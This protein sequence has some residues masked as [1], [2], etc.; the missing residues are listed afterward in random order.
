M[1][2]IYTLLSRFR[3]VFR[4]R[5]AE[6]ELNDELRF[7]IELETEKNI[8]EGFSPHEAR[9]RALI[10]FGAAESYKEMLRDRRAVRWLHD[11]HADTRY[12]LRCL[13]RS[14]GF[15]IVAVLTLGLGIGATTAIFAVVNAVLLRPLPYRDSGELAII[16][17]QNPERGRKGS[18][19]SYL[20]YQTW[21]RE[22]QSFEGLAVFNW[23]TSTISGDDAQAERVAG[24]EVDADLFHVL[25]VEPLLGRGVR[26]EEQVVG[27]DRVVVLGYGLWQRRYGGDGGV[28]GRS[29]NVDGQPHVIIGVMP[30]GFRFPNSRELWLP[31]A[32][33]ESYAARSSRFLAGAVSRLRKGVTREQAEAELARVSGRLQR[34]FPESNTGWEGQYVALRDD[35]V[36]TL[37]PAILIVFAAAGL[38]L[39]IACGNLAS[40]LLAR[41]A[42][43][44]REI[45]LRAAIGARRGRLM[46]QFLTET[47]V[48]TLLG[49]LLGLV[50]AYWGG[51]LL[52]GVLADR[53]PA[54]IH[55]TPDLRV[56]AFAV[57]ATALI[58]VLAG[59]A[60]ALQGTGVNVQAVMKVGGRTTAGP[61]GTRAR[62]VLVIAEVALAVVL[63]IGSA[64]LIKSMGALSRIEAGFEPRNVLTARYE[65]PESKYDSPER[66][67]IFQAALFEQ[68]RALPGVLQVGAAAG[69]PFSGWNAKSSYEVEGEGVA[70]TGN[71]PSTHHQGD[72]GVLRGA[73]H[74][75]R[76]R[77]HARR[78]GRTGRGPGRGGE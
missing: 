3:A 18:N 21:K 73:R 53:I 9:R 54:V 16:Y 2:A 57:A 37:R 56:F 71:E 12:A 69:M 31:M 50:V 68:L 66:R 39:L 55:I 78:Y 59:V 22:L 32:P 63:L 34:D 6:R 30:P 5:A 19:I 67:L 42:G 13:S 4:H 1:D 7:H 47:I 25:G 26:P 52:R 43:R 72:T 15:T 48:L 64:L 11:A 38:V 45:A 74:S 40:L 17:A 75:A 35:L 10:S 46:R 51:G 49:G 36:G 27:R 29:I 62:R 23:V 8:R 28:L 44:A 33:D 14:R 60:P 58:A 24:T 20:D 61:R 77:A 41:G 70:A 65:L 76:A